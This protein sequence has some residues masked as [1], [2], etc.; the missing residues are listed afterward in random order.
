[1]NYFFTIIVTIMHIA[2]HSANVIE[3]V[4]IVVS[5]KGTIARNRKTKHEH[6]YP[7]TVSSL[8][9]IAEGPALYTGQSQQRAKICD[10]HA[11]S[12]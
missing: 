7:T 1:M 3:R 6:A 8:Y 9:L 2:Y 11:G 4:R 10:N 12:L 5:K